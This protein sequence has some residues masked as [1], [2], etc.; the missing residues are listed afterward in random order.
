MAQLMTEGA[1][2]ALIHIKLAPMDGQR[3]V[4][5]TEQIRAI[6]TEETPAD[7]ELRI[8][9]TKLEP[10]AEL[11]DRETV[12]RLARLTGKE[13]DIE[14]LRSGKTKPPKALIAKVVE[15]RDSLDDPDEGIFAVDIPDAE[16][17]S[18]KPEELLVLRGKKLD[19]YM[20][21]K[22][23]TAVAEDEEGIAPSAEH[24]GAWID[25]E[26]GKYKVEGWCAAL[27]FEDRCDELRPALSEFD[28][29]SWA[30][31]PDLDLPKDAEVRE[32]PAKFRLTGQPVIGQAFAESVTRSLLASTAVSIVALSLVLLLAR[33]L[34]A[35]IP[36]LWTLAFSAGI[37]AALGHPISVGTSMV[38]CIALGAGVDFAIHLGFRAR[39]YRKDSR[40]AADGE[41]A[42]RE[43]GAVIVISAVQLALAFSVLLFSEMPPLQQFGVGLSI[44]LIGAALGAVWFTPTLLRGGKS[45]A[46]ESKT[47][48]SKTKA[49]K[50]DA[51][52]SEPKA[53]S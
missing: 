18:M 27:D 44:G 49:S 5:V 7:D 37:I 39:S 47:E 6:L 21:E 34:F 9:S 45:K 42:V 10:V 17:K 24:L 50:A 43:L 33:S 13:I 40:R 36:A 48:A 12:A 53:D 35:L 23:P 25:E 30:I 2:G 52:A 22:L 14:E 11:R 51:D 32:H 29:E 20:R 16:M 46:K 38:A 8:A 4:E 3:Q 28:D 26:K 41:R 31:P 15:L 1:D 19:K